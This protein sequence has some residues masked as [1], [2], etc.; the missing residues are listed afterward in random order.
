MARSA[1]SSLM[2]TNPSG[3]GDDFQVRIHE[4]PQVSRTIPKKQMMLRLTIA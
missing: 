2:A 1:A 4:R 3:S